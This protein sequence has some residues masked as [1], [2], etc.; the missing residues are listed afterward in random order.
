MFLIW[1]EI[2]VKIAIQS[3]RLIVQ[4]ILMDTY[5]VQGIMMMNNISSQIG[6]YIKQFPIEDTRD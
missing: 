4:G 1:W 6:Q 2:S 5:I 3:Q